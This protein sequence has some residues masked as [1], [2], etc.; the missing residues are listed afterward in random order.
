[1]KLSTKALLFLFTSKN[2]SCILSTSTPSEEVRGITHHD[3][4]AL[5]LHT[6]TP[7][8]NPY[9]I[10]YEDGTK[11]PLIQLKVE[12]DEFDGKVYEETLDGFTVTPIQGGKYYTYLDVDE[13]TGDTVE[14]NLIA[15][16]DDPYASK[17]HKQAFKRAQEIKTHLPHPFGDDGKRKLLRRSSA[18]D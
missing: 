14:T 11:S 17:V 13:K 15:G 4:G 2:I 7:N 8:P 12:G 3:S 16:V 5:S 9:Q 18:R 10:T 1:M 6:M